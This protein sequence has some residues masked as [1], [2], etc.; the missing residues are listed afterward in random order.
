M[1]SSRLPGKVMKPILGRPVLALLIE[2]IKVIKLIDEIVIATT[3]NKNDD[4]LERLSRDIGVGCFRG[5]EEDVLARV[6]GAAKSVNADLIVEITGDCP[7]VDPG[8]ITGCI[9]LLLEGRYDYVSNVY[10]EQTFPDG[11]AVQVFPVKILEEISLLTD[12]PADRE[13]VS[14]YIYSHPEKYRLKNYPARGELYWPDLAV[15]LDTQQDYELIKI[16]FEELYP[17]NPAFTIYD[18][19][20]FLRHSPGLIK[21]SE[22]LERRNNYLSSRPRKKAN[23]A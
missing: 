12:D 18:I 4:I 17:K 5:S 21:L 6:L 9:K 2:R 1:S 7:L 14:L 13:H 23:V 10:S 3:I 20:R 11:L 22:D 8:I 15:T 19:V 16:I